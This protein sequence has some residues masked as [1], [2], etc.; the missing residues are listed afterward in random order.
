MKMRMYVVTVLTLALMI[1]LSASAQGVGKRVERSPA[2][3]DLSEEQRESMETLRMEHRMEM[4]DLQAEQRKLRLEMMMELKESDPDRGKLEAILDKIAAVEEKIGRRR[5]AHLL[6]VRKVLND[7]Q[8]KIFLRRRHGGFKAGMDRGG[9]PLHG[10][11]G[12]DMMHRRP[13]RGGGD[14]D[15]GRPHRRGHMKI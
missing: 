7:D 1:P 4:I 11:R 13:M 12:P 9:R 6:D 15:F 10:V 2:A 8:W 3:L 14:D 5:L